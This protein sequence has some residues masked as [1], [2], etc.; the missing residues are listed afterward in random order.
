MGNRY[1]FWVLIR[2]GMGFAIVAWAASYIGTGSGEKEFQKTVDAL[3]QVHSFRVASSVNAGVQRNEN[4]WEVDCDRNIAHHRWHVVVNSTDPPQEIDQDQLNVEGRTYQ[5]DKDGSWSPA[6]YS[7]G[8]VG[9]GRGYCNM[10]AQGA[11][12][13]IFPSFATMIRRGIL[14]KGDT[15]TVNGVRCREW[16]VTLRINAVSLDHDTVCLGLKDHLP[17]EMTIGN[18]ANRSLYSDYNA[19]IQFEVPDSALQSASDNQQSN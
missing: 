10:L 1:W 12:G 18:A 19:P 7:A 17:Y 4:L 8:L 16:L 3:K 6:K 15:K 2:L 11:D 14:D 13:N 9:Q 5:R